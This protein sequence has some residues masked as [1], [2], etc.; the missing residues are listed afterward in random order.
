MI[1]T[2]RGVLRVRKWPKKRGTPKSP[3][4]RWWNDW[5]RQANLLAKYADGMTQARAIALTK[6][7]GLYPRDIILKAMRGRLYIFHDENGKVWYPMAAIQDISDSLDVL[8]QNIGSVLVRATDRWR[9][10]P[11]G[12]VNDVLT[13]KGG[14]APPIWQAPA[15]AGGLVQETLPGYPITPDGSLNAYELNVSAYS[16][17]SVVLDGIGFV[18]SD[19]PILTLSIDG[20]ATFKTGGTDYRQSYVTSSGGGGADVALIHLTPNAVAA[21]H[22]SNMNL[23]NVKAGRL[24]WSGMGDTSASYSTSRSGFA[25]FDS[26]VTNIRISSLSGSNFN[27][28]VIRVVGTR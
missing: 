3:L 5:F 19:R 16:L 28:G 7:T 1:D 10:P 4:Q 20:G 21:N 11:T 2:V 27:A 15:T 13:Y 26:P 9:A 25:N 22:N 24:S 6:G 8:A 18:S 12:N 14:A 17:L 23:A